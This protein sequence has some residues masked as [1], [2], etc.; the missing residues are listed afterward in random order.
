[1]GKLAKSAMERESVSGSITKGAGGLAPV[2]SSGCVCA[3]PSGI[4]R[5]LLP[6][7]RPSRL[8]CAAAGLGQPIAVAM[9][10]V[11]GGGARPGAPARASRALLPAGPIGYAPAPPRP[12]PHRGF[13]TR[14]IRQGCAR[15]RRR[16][17]RGGGGGS[18]AAPG[19]AAAS[20]PG[21]GREGGGQV[22]RAGRAVRGEPGPLP[23]ERGGPGGAARGTA[24]PRPQLIPPPPASCRSVGA[25]AV[26]RVPAGTAH[27][28]PAERGAPAASGAPSPAAGSGHSRCPCAL[29][30]RRAA[31]GGTARSCPRPGPRRREWGLL[32]PRSP[33]R[34]AGS[35][36]SGSCPRKGGPRAAGRGRPALRAAASNPASCGPGNGPARLCPLRALL[37]AAAAARTPALQRG[38]SGGAVGP[39]S[40]EPGRRERGRQQRHGCRFTDPSVG[41]IPPHAHG[42]GGRAVVCPNEAAPSRGAFPAAGTLRTLSG[43][44]EQRFRRGRGAPVRPGR[45]GSLCCVGSGRS[46]PRQSCS[47]GEGVMAPAVPAGSRCSPLGRQDA[48]RV[49]PC[50][51]LPSCLEPRQRL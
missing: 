37:G 23:R 45:A 19:W 31:A 17:R 1:M 20:R 15:G 44:S 39:T 33:D 36:R 40:P 16:S 6:S 32:R 28:G 5:R 30:D 4:A 26:P 3:S 2:A 14:G 13:D 7:L 8:R 34:S 51:R 10:A 27:P 11:C 41:A 25:A 49:P 46:Q 50:S 43:M 24:D 29:R 9:A 48:G 35:G 38:G 18:R 21:E 47:A 12:K 42:C 22:G